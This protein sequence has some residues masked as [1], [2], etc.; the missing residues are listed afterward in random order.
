MIYAYINDWEKDGLPQTEKERKRADILKYA[1]NFNWTIN[2][3]YIESHIKAVLAQMNPGDILLTPEISSLGVSLRD[4][5][6]LIKNC[7]DYSFKIIVVRDNYIFDNGL[8]TQLLALAMETVIKIIADIKSQNMQ[9]S[10]RRLRRQGKTLGRPRGSV[11]KSLKLSGHEDV[12]RKLL[13]Q[14][15]SRSEI[16]RKLGVNR[17]TLYSFLEKMNE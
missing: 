11:N 13:A 17:M 2:K 16:S 8:N 5:H 1:K 7:I 10:L 3:W 4:I 12:I 6:K 9:K 14:N 15:V